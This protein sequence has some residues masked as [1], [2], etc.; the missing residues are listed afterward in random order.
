MRPD[1]V[2]KSMRQIRKT[3]GATP[4][5]PKLLT[6]ANAFNTKAISGANR[7]DGHHG[8]DKGRCHD[9]GNLAPHQS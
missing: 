4:V 5:N 9:Q 6:A 3:L 1:A 8:A 2:G 7:P